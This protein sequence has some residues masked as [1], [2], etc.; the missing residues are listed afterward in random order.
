MKN[1]DLHKDPNTFR[2]LLFENQLQSVVV[3]ELQ[4]KYSSLLEN[5]HSDQ[6]NSKNKIEALL[7]ENYSLKDKLEG[8]G[9]IFNLPKL[10]PML[11]LKGLP[12]VSTE[13]L[14]LWYSRKSLSYS[15]PT[16]LISVGDL[17]KFL[18]QF[19]ISFLCNMSPPCWTLHPKTTPTFLGREFPSDQS[20]SQAV[21]TFGGISGIELK[22]MNFETLVTASLYLF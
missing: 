4:N 18:I 2:S 21:G 10:E 6:K 15:P 13:I 19:T 9:P 20:K 7:F 17:Q 14:S 1:N 5:F 8:N 22:L 11:Q 3:E 12:N 16:Q